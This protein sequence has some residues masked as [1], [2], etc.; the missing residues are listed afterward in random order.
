MREKMAADVQKTLEQELPKW[1][2]GK[3]TLK[4]I[5]GYTD[6]ELY[7]IAHM[8]YFYL[9]Q[10][11]TEEAKVLFEGLV[12]LDPMNGYYYRALGVIFYKLGEADRAL[13]QFGYA[14][15]VAP[16]LPHAYVNRAEVNLALG[17]GPKAAKDLKQALAL[18]GPKTP[19]LRQKAQ[20]L[21]LALNTD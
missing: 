12:A 1:A 6:H 5:K 18:M 21:L 11:K 19:Q 15:R 17:K 10:G 14:I 8:A 3:T 13:R 7:A 4:D 20:A 2:E 9:K 16:G